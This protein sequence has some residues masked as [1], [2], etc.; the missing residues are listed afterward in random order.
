[1]LYSFVFNSVYAVLRGTFWGNKQ[2]F[3]Y[4]VIE[5]LEEAVMI[6]VGSLLVVGMT[7]VVDGAKRAAF[8][9]VVSYLTSF[10][11]AMIYFFCKGGKFVNPY[12]QFR[13]LLSSAMPITAMRTSASLVNS[14]ISVLLP[15]RLMLY[16]LTAAQAMS[17]YGVALG[18]AIPVL[19]TPATVIGSIALVLTP[20]ISD[21]FYREQHRRL[22]IALSKALQV[23]VFISASMIPLFFV[24]GS[25]MGMILYSSAR[26]GEIIRNAAAMLL[27]MSLNMISSSM[28]NSLGCE[29]KTLL[30]YFFGAAIM[31]LAVWFL[32]RYIGIYALIVGQFLNHLTCAF[33]NLRLLRKKCV[34]PPAYKKFTLCMIV[35]L[36]AESLL[37][38]IVYPL[39]LR[40]MSV[41]P[42]MI[43]AGAG[44]VLAEGVMLLPTGAYRALLPLRYKKKIPKTA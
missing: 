13:P 10:T 38:Q 21:C 40:V 42:A 43:L 4:S 23:T 7:D 16:G 41:F 22:Q 20:E 39:C 15:S 12:G 14:L 25:D 27:P 30:Y 44:M 5:F 35:I 34:Y 26:S 31:L 17:E 6:A 19:Y 8:A 37:G 11:I 32:P 3:A 2:F 1:M 29:K 24:F 28:L 36:L 33:L 18:M 9:V